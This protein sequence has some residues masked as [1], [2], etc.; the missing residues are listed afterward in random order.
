[1]LCAGKAGRMLGADKAFRSK[2]HLSVLGR[3]V[4]SG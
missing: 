1:M 4:L 2:L 3:A